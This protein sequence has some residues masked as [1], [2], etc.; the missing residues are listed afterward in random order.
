MAAACLALAG[1]SA[2]GQTRDASPPAS[3]Y[4]P[5][6]T[7]P[8]PAATRSSPVQP[9]SSAAPASGS[10]APRPPLRLSPRSSTRRQPISK[11]A[12]PSVG[13]AVGTVVGSLGLVLGLFL[14]IAWAS[15]RLAPAGAAPLPKEAVELLG[16][17]PLAGR[18]QLRLLRVGN[19]LLLVAVSPTGMET[20][21]EITESAEVEHLLALCRRG[22]TGSAQAEFQEALHELAREPADRSRIAGSGAP[23]R[24]VQ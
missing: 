17:A 8:L 10:A 20:L 5:V 18:Q 13:G 14:A 7:N 11:P 12:A 24:G 2:A 3:Y 6:S 21:T 23:L 1:A 15:R 19:K 22:R 9:A 16:H 4:L